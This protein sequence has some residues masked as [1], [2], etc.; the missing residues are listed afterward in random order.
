MSEIA[1]NLPILLCCPALDCGTV[2]W[3]SRLTRTSGGKR[4]FSLSKFCLDICEINRR[5]YSRNMQ[6]ATGQ[7]SGSFA[8]V[9]VFL[10]DACCS[11][12]LCSPPW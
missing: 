11:I 7:F 1:Y 12:L 6:S 4:G 2:L 10:N 9:T 8:T 3:K 5:P